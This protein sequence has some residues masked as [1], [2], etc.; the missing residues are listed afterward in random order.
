VVLVVLA[1]FAS[2]GWAE[3]QWV[4]C[5]DGEGRFETQFRTGVTVLVEAAKSGGLAS[6]KCSA[7]LHWGE[8]SLAVTPT[9]AQVDVDV[10]GADLGLGG[11]TVA[12]VLRSADDEWHARYL[13]Y[14]LEKPARLLRTITGGD[15][16]SAEDADF[17]GRIAIWTGGR[18]GRRFRPAEIWGF[19]FCANGGSG[20]PTRATDGCGR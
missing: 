3:R 8:T 5:E 16:Y 19:R 13:I 2:R 7:E 20:I 9:D 4:L 18:G 1:C 14:S 12:F 10:L 11:P 17:D 6:R 15:D